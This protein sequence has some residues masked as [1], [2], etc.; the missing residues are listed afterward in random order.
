[1]MS[2][3]PVFQVD[4]FSSELF[5]GNPAAVV[6]LDFWL[7]DHIMQAIAAENNLSE[8][9][10]YMPSGHDFELRWFT[11]T[12]EVDLCGHATLATAH[13]L[14]QEY[15]WPKDVLRF[16][17]RSGLLT[18]RHNQAAYQMSFPVD[19]IRQISTPPLL[20][21]ALQADIS[22]TW[23]GRSDMMAILSSADALWRLSP[24][25][26][27]LT[28]LGGRGILVTAPGTEGADFV[29]RCFFPAVGVPEDPVTGSAHTTLTPYWAA[30]LG[31]KHLVA[32]QLSARG[33]E[34]RCLLDDH[35][36]ILEGEA[37]TFLTGTI[38]IP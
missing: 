8:T 38:R 6:P 3:R 26:D 28:E 24:N 31:K 5:K 11:P 36:V 27:L 29:S 9:A 2:S 17:T 13:V 1:M 22:S 21:K 10:F 14:F 34:I 18:V 4:A 25:M 7:P 35:Q 19:I 16:H 20:S 37:V 12:T 15:Q 33:G 32:R 23:Q 30:Q